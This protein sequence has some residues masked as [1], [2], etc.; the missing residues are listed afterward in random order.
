[1]TTT[2]QDVIMMAATAVDPAL[3]RNTAKLANA[4]IPTTSRVKVAAVLNS[5]AMAIVTM[6]MQ[7]VVTMAAI[8]VDPALVRNTAKLANAWIPTTSRVKV[9]AVLNSKAMAIV[10]MTTTM[11]DVVTMAAI[12]VDP[13]LVRNT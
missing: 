2:M 3:V 5:K 4:W 9:A 6:T 10:T 12:A 13:A 1:M 8:A 11:Q 7:D